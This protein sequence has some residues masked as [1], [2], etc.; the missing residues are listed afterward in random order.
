MVS[1]MNHVVCSK[2]LKCTSV[3]TGIILNFKL[4]FTESGEILLTDR[5]GRY[6][7]LEGSLCGVNLSN[8]TVEVVWSENTEHRGSFV[9]SLFSY[10]RQSP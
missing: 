1:K 7:A 2:M 3:H 10:F 6:R 5:R 8:V 4:T 9:K